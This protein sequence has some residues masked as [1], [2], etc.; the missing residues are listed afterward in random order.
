MSAGQTQRRPRARRAAH[1]A[2][3]ARA[4]AADFAAVRARYVRLYVHHDNTKTWW[5][6]F[7]V[8]VGNA[9]G[10]SPWRGR[11]GEGKGGEGHIKQ[12]TADPR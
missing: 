6:L 8:K 9:A 7:G 12:K 10:R 1:P 4:P 3:I 11:E 2:G 5:Q